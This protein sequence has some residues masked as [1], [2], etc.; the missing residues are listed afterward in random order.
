MCSSSAIGW[1]SS[2]SG[3]FST[4]N[5][6]RVVASNVNNIPGVI[7]CQHE[8]IC[9][10][11]L[12]VFL[13]LMTRWLWDTA[14]AGATHLSKRRPIAQC[15]IHRVNNAIIC[16]YTGPD[17]MEQSNTCAVLMLTLYTQWPGRHQ[18]SKATDMVISHPEINSFLVPSLTLGSRSLCDHTQCISGYQR[19]AEVPLESS[20]LTVRQGQ[21]ERRGN[22]G[23]GQTLL[24]AEK[25][26]KGQI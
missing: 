15:L 5:T 23:E 24:E 10:C 13:Y 1:F 20:S 18:G 14:K 25:T 6:E 21:G 7:N 26:I 3:C 4:Y 2:L 16:L 8:C 11:I 17:K 9:L 12:C 22:R 19:R